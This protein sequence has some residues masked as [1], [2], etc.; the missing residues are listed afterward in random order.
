MVEDRHFC[1]GAGVV[2]ARRIETGS[3][4]VGRQPRPWRRD[5][6][7]LIVRDGTLLSMEEVSGLE[8]GDLLVLITRTENE[9]EGLE[10]IRSH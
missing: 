8:A 1:G 9:K 4:L 3:D 6:R 10:W 5:G 7:V 2:L